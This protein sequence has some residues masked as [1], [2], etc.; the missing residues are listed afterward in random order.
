ME[1]K[2]RA[3]VLI[4]AYLQSSAQL[5]QAARMQEELIKLGVQTDVLRNDGFYAVVGDN[6]IKTELVEKYD[7]CVYFDKDKYVSQ[8][9][10]KAGLRLFN[11][12]EAI[13]VCDDKMETYIALSGKNIPGGVFYET[14][15]F[16]PCLFGGVC[17]LFFCGGVF[18]F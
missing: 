3:L 2:K 17:F 1:K 13:R 10:E 16:C 11:N 6:K 4:N 5:S 8:M 15:Y 9:L 12:H 18:C 14:A 7:F